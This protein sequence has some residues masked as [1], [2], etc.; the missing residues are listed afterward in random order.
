MPAVLFLVRGLRRNQ[1]EMVVR[2]ERE[3]AP[4]LVSLFF[5]YDG[6]TRTLYSH[7]AERKGSWRS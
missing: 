5:G 3:D 2:E 4:Y 6:S 7:S 1:K